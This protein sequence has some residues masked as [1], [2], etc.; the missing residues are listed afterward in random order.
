[1]TYSQFWVYLT[2]FWRT[3]HIFNL[4]FAIGWLD[5]SYLFTPCVDSSAWD[6]LEYFDICNCNRNSRHE[7][8]FCV[9]FFCSSK[10]KLCSLWL[11]LN[12]LSC[13]CQKWPPFSSK[14]LWYGLTLKDGH[15]D[16]DLDGDNILVNHDDDDEVG[17]HSSNIDVKSVVCWSCFWFIDVENGY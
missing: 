6:Y 16:K 13:L 3:F 11:A 8:T 5:G 4:R 15:D 2:W 12:G 14:V 10:S 1:M 17:H 7:C 9:I